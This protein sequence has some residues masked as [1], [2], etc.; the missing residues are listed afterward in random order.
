MNNTQ[1]EKRVAKALDALTKAMATEGEH[2]KVWCIDQAVQ[3]LTGD[4]YSNFV[5][6]FEEE[7]GLE[8]DRGIE[9]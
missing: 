5:K 8:W 9:A 6:R 4:A 1:L 3:V 2:H 7:K